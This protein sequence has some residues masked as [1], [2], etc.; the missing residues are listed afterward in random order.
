MPK[1]TIGIQ[2]YN[3]LDLLKI[4]STSLYRSDLSISP[5]I[6]IYDDCSTDFGKDTLEMIFPTAQA[7]KINNVNLNADKNM[8]QMYVDF[9]STNDDYFFNADS[10]I[11]FNSQ[12]LNKAIE[13]IDKTDGIL[14]L[15]NTSAHKPYKIIDDTFCLKHSLGAAGTMFKRDCVLKLLNH[16]DSM[17]KVTGF[18]WQWSEYFRTNDTKLYCVNNSLI[19]HIGYKGVHSKLYFDIGKGFEIETVEDAQVVNDILV[20]YMNHIFAFEKGYK[21]RENSFLY[22]FSKC[23]KISARK[24]LPH[25]LQ[26]KLNRIFKKKKTST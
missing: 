18:D 16:F 4:M 13:M 14:S 2:T 25:F 23:A 22:H 6:R 26:K 15:F 21:I 5:N 7:I 20:D 10:D 1:I 8:Y 24:I 17:E 9:L 11:I 19:Q 12:W 3:R